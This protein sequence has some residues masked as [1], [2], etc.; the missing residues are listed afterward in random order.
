[1][2]DDLQ[3]KMPTDLKISHPHL[4]WR[5]SEILNLHS[6]YCPSSRVTIF[7]PVGK[8]VCQKI[9][10]S[11]QIS[12]SKRIQQKLMWKRALLNLPNVES[13]VTLTHNVACGSGLRSHK[14]QMPYRRVKEPMWRK[15]FM[16][17][18][19]KLKPTYTLE[20]CSK[21]KIRIQMMP[22]KCQYQAVTSTTIWRVSNR[23]RMKLAS[24]AHSK[25]SSPPARWAA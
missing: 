25:T 18:Y 15:I 6:Q 13:S 2:L 20:K 4:S 7:L 16:F 22:M 23:L 24:A 8:P 17:S 9:R 14:L 12:P 1:M 19:F 3:N 11:I 10:T 21:A 5:Y